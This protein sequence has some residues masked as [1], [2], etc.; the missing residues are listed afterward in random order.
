MK[1][2]RRNTII[3]IIIII[4]ILVASRPAHGAEFSDVTHRGGRGGEKGAHNGKLPEG[5]G[6][7]ISEFDTRPND[8]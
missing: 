5:S 4:T 2:N 8:K 1:E 7:A 6:I 3:I